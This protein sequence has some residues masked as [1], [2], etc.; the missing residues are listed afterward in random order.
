MVVIS[1]VKT[2]GSK[3]APIAFRVI[4][5]AVLWAL[6][7]WDGNLWEQHNLGGYF[8]T[9]DPLRFHQE[10][11]STVDWWSQAEQTRFDEFLRSSNTSDLE[12]LADLLNAFWFPTSYTK[13]EHED[14][15]QICKYIDDLIVVGKE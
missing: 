7:S 9:T 11:P 1:V 8:T 13:L 14:N 4:T 5:K 15:V 6:C 10:P 12:E 2:F 3:L